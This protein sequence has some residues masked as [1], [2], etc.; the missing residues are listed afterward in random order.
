[1]IYRVKNWDIYFE[2]SDTRKCKN[3]KWVALPN[4]MDGSSFRRIAEHDRKCELFS[5]WILIIEIASRMPIRG[6]LYKDGK[7]LT[8]KDMAYRTGFPEE[9]FNLAFAVLTEPEI[10]WLETVAGNEII[11]DREYMKNSVLTE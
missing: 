6:L 5:A 8:S 7:A 9:I 10:G 11:Q 1:M 3:M 2:K 4:K